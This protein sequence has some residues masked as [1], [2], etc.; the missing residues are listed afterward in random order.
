[1]PT[2]GLFFPRRAL[3]AAL[4]AVAGLASQD[5]RAQGAV[6]LE[7]GRYVAEL[8]RARG[9]QAHA[10]LRSIQS[11]WDATDPEALSLALDEASRTAADPAARVYAEILF[12]DA[13]SRRGDF[14]GAGARMASLGYIDKWLFVG[15][16]DDQNR[17]GLKAAYQ[18]ELELAEPIVFGRAFDGKER[19]VRWRSVLPERASV[20]LD[21]GDWIRPRQEVCAYATTIVRHRAGKPKASR[22]SVWVGVEGAFKLWWNGDPVLEDAAYRGFDFD[23]SAA[24][25]DVRDGANRLTVKVCSDALSPRLAVRLG[26]ER[27]AKSDALEAV[28]DLALFETAAKPSGKPATGSKLEGPIQ[29]FERVTSAKTASAADLEAYARYLKLTRGNPRGEHRAR[30]LASRAAEAG[31]S[32]Q[33]LLLAAELAEDRNQSQAFVDRA[34]KIVARGDDE[35]EVAVLLMKARLARTGINWRDAI[36]FFDK[37][38]AIDPANPLAAL[39]RTELYAQA[40]LPRTALSVLERAVERSPRS[41]SLL[42]VYAAQLRSLGREVEADEVDAR[43]YAFRADDAAF[44]ARQLDRAVAKRDKST[45]ERWMSRLVRNEPDLVFAQAAAARAYRSLGETVKARRALEVALEIAPEDQGTLRALA[46]LAGESGDRE[47]QLRHLR[48]VLALY[49]QDKAV[50]S[51]VEYLLPPKPREDEALAWNKEKLLELAKRPAGTDKTR[52]LRKLTVTTVYPN[53]LASRFYQVAYQPLTDEAAAEARQYLT[54]YEGSKQTIELRAARVYRADGSVAEAVESGESAANNPAMAMYTSVR[55]FA[56]TFPRVSPGDIVEVRYRVDDVASRNEVADAYYDIEYL[57]AREKTLSSELVVKAPKSRTLTAFLHNLPNVK[58]SVTETATER[59]YRFVAE[60]VPGLSVEPNMPPDGEILGQIHLSTFKSWDELA[61]WY[62]GLAR[63]QLD[64]DDEV[65]KQAKE[66]AAKAKDDA[67]KVKAVY[68]LATELRYVAL[69]L[70]IEGIKPR[71]CALTLARGWGDCKDKATV[72]VTLLRELGIPANLVLVRTQQRGDLPKG[73]PPSLA[74]FDH[75]IAYVPSLDL[76]LDGTA[77]GSGSTE[78]PA[79]DRDAVALV[80][81]DAGGKLVRLPN[82]AATASPH[83]RKIELSLASD[84][85]AAFS[86][87]TTVTGVNASAWRSRYHAEGQQID[88]A[89]RDLATFFGTVEMGKDSVAVKDADDIEKP[90]RMTAKGKALAAARREGDA[91]SVPVAASLDLVRTVGSLSSRQTD[92]VVGALTSSEEERVIRIPAGMKV[93]RLPVN[94]KVT[95]PLG[96]VEVTVENEGNRVVIKSKLAILKSRISPSEYAS[97]RAF[98][99]SADDALSQRLVVGP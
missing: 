29:A 27:G 67:A 50:R 99:Q 14:E 6:D 48:R 38:L 22:A 93:K 15:P 72:I 17:T 9:P 16:F 26:D 19:A 59:T 35:G 94:A 73:S 40:G 88:R 60:D 56:V 4:V 33:R 96:Y 39:G 37:A 69:E 57:Q 52:V 86:F 32:W 80:V 97:F 64:V 49:P 13:R 65:R 28:T 5:A 79:M 30:D 55:A 62:Y 11:L 10:A 61:K 51:Y 44:A 70:G 12:A 83:V 1:M 85:S 7:L 45:A 41:V 84:A 74:A 36:P 21:L 77:E 75:A 98:C 91:L 2:P 23:R 82:A 46:D 24:L 42:R 92:V 66:I 78:L 68:K 25:V 18:P 71:R 47:L 81:S 89:K 58:Q 3:V 90:F 54:Q 34:D 53:G 43:W 95:T 31:P 87:D 76:Y 8:G 63:D 20:V